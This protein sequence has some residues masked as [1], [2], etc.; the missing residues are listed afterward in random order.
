MTKFI[1]LKYPL[2]L[3]PILL[4]SGPFLPDLVISLG[5]IFFLFLCIKN[6]EFKS[7]KEI[8]FI[9]FFIFLD[10]YIT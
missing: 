7:F 6:K 1:H 9:F 10:F 5:S 8:H 3:L 2:L 4:V